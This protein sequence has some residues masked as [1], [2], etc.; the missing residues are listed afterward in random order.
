MIGIKVKGKFL[1]TRQVSF[2]FELNSP[3]YFGNDTDVI[4]GSIM[5]STKIPLSDHNSL[6][7]Q[8]PDIITHTTPL[9]LNEYC[10]VWAQGS[11]LFAGELTVTE[12]SEKDITIEIII[13][14]ISKLKEIGLNE[15]EY[16]R[17]QVGD[18]DNLIAIAN[19]TVTHPNDSIPIIFTPVWN[20]LQYG[21]ESGF[22]DKSYQNL[23]KENSFKVLNSS[24]LT[25]FPKVTHL[26]KMVIESV[27]FTLINAFQDT[28]ELKWMIIYNN[29]SLVDSE[30]SLISNQIDLKNHVSKTK[31]SDFVKRFC[32][33]WCLGIFTNYFSK[34]VEIKSLDSILSDAPRHNWTKCAVKGYTK[35]EKR[36]YPNKFSNDSYGTALPSDWHNQK[37]FYRNIGLPSAE[38]GLYFQ[39]WGTWVYH[40]QPEPGIQTAENILIE[41]DNFREF[42]EGS[43][44]FSTPL[45]HLPQCSTFTMLM[46]CVRL[47]GQV[48]ETKQEFED[49]LLFYRGLVNIGGG[50]PGDQSYYPLSS[51]ESIDMA[52]YPIKIGINGTVNV[53]NA[54]PAGVNA[55]RSMMWNGTEGVYEKSWATWRSFLTQKKEVT[56]L[57][58]M[59]AEDIRSFSFSHKVMIHN[60]IY[61]VKKMTISPDVSGEYFNVKA[62]LVTVV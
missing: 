4:E 50:R 1:D 55:Q 31:V 15:V 62:E 10:E 18:L 61:L 11:I 43:V 25:P 49:G 26:L 7:L 17:I 57:L 32:R 9:L 33:F 44:A 34:T 16:D 22:E 24:T 2:S 52:G 12:A 51:Q 35:T 56:M 19:R 54:L 45:Q 48:D 3:V 6:L 20:P 13:N 5:F 59:T 29:Y 21:E 27:G 14:S 53:N 28:N 41:M 39:S 30:G 37:R 47:I 23:W 42:T 46:P 36:N 38:T 40:V 8:S 58:K 60:M